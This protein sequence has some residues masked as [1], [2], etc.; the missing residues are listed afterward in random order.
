MI[1]ILIK[2]IAV[3]L[4]YVFVIKPVSLRVAGKT[5][6]NI[7]AIEKTFWWMSPAPAGW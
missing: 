1:K 3:Y 2:V 7:E 5:A 4:L 6:A